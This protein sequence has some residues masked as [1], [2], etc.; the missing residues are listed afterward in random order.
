MT[1]PDPAGPAVPG[2]HVRGVLGGRRLP[3]YR[4]EVPPRLDSLLGLAAART[5]HPP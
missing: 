1:S 5:G 2:T 3:G 4:W